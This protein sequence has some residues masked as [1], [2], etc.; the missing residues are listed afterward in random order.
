[1][2]RT[3]SSEGTM[4]EPKAGKTKVVAVVRSQTSA[5][6]RYTISLHEEGGHRHLSCS[7]PAWLYQPKPVWARTC[8]HIDAL[9]ADLF[10][11]EQVA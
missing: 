2:E 6:K 10:S 4:A 8:K 5:S 9:Q 3:S 7:C 11:A 1:M